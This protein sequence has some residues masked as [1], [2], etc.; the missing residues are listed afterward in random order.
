MSPAAKLHVPLLSE[1]KPALRHALVCGAVFN[2]STS[3]IG[4]VIMSI[5]ATL[6]VLSVIPGFL[7]ILVIALLSDVS[8]EFLMGFTHSG[9]TT[10]YAGVMKESF[11]WVEIGEAGVGGVRA[12]GVQGKKACAPER[13][14]KKRDKREGEDRGR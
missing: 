10:T 5:P 3:T 12:H 11:G 4:P 2:V 9:D 6:K 14:M 8:V 7:L 1:H 13:E